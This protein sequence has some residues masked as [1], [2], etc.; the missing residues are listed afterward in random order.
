MTPTRCVRHSQ[1][2]GRPRNSRWQLLNLV[3][4]RSRWHKLLLIDWNSLVSMYV[5]KL[6]LDFHTSSFRR[7]PVSCFTFPSPA[8]RAAFSTPA[9][10]CRVFQSRIFSAPPPVEAIQFWCWSNFGCDSRITFPL[11]LTSRGSGSARREG[12]PGHVPRL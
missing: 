10:W 3:Q 2:R 1:P 7:Y 9:V 12:Q 5:V 6:R 4:L 11:F 8:K